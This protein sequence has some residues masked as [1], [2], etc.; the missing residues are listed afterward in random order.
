[1]AILVFF[2]IWALILGLLIQKITW[3][4]VALFWVSFLCFWLIYRRIKGHL[5]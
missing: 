3:W 4:V 5:P 2:L 1:M